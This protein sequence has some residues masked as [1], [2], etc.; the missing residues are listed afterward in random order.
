MSR[1]FDRNGNLISFE[2]WC[3][4]FKEPYKRIARDNIDDK[5][6]ISTVWLGV[7]H[8]WDLSGPPLIFETMAFIDGQD[9]GLW[10]YSTETEAREGHARVVARLKESRK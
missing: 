8:Q 2:E 6:M 9:A 3:Q 5:C 4:K 1:C 7:D 10:R